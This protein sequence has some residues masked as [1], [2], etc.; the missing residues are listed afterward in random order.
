MADN[1]NK[2]K[3]KKKELKEILYKCP[4]EGCDTQLSFSTPKSAIWICGIPKK[5]CSLC[6]S[7]G[8]RHLS[9]HGGAPRTWNAFTEKDDDS[10]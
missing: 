3:Q 5:V 7:K 9:G 2:L 6:H 10:E 4:V 8:W 1:S